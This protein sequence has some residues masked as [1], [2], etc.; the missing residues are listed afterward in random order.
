MPG[1]LGV[2][3]CTDPSRTGVLSLSPGDDKAT[4]WA[5]DTEGDGGITECARD[6]DGVWGNMEAARERDGVRGHSRSGGGGARVHPKRDVRIAVSEDCVSGTAGDDRE[7][8][9]VGV[10][11]GSPSDI[12]GVGTATE[13]KVERSE[14]IC[15]E[16][17]SSI[18]NI[19]LSRS[20][21]MHDALKD[22]L[23]LHHIILLPI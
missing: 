17:S 1:I 2:F 19:K 21:E 18:V 10:G 16:V 7:S 9:V 11:G 6:M 3:G 22:V 8:A 23:L 15:I 12:G 5:R 14:L 4:D 20:V 13:D